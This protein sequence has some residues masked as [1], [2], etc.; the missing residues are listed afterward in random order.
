MSGFL[1]Q[2]YQNN[3]SLID[4]PVFAGLPVAR[5]IYRDPLIAA[6]FKER[7]ED[8]SVSDTIWEK[9]TSNKEMIV[10]FLFA[11]SLAIFYFLMHLRRLRPAMLG[12]V[13]LSISIHMYYMMVASCTAAVGRYAA[14]FEPT[15]L[16]SGLGH[17]RLVHPLHC[18]TLGPVD[19]WCGRVGR[20][21][22]DGA[23]RESYERALRADPETS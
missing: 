5:N 1:N 11:A 13:F 3:Q 2:F 9:F 6:R 10:V 18:H 7:Q 14:A 17:P 4:N 19:D 15:L 23:E 21:D 20:F 8:F 22:Q 16:D 12:L